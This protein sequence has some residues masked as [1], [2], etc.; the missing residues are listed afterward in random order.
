MTGPNTP[1]ELRNRL[2]DHIVK[3]NVAGLYDPRVEQAMRTVPRHDFIPGASLADAY[4]NRAV[5]IKDNPDADALP[6]SCASQPDVVFFM[7]AQL[8]IQPGDNI[9]EAGAGT[10]YNAALMRH[11]AGPSGQV[12]TLDIHDDVAAHARQRLDDTGFTDVRVLTR[13]AAIGAPEYGPYDRIIATVGIWD[14]PGHL[15]GPAL[16]RWPARP[17][18]ALARPDAQ[19]RLRQGSPLPP[20]GVRRHLRL[21]PDDR[22]GRRA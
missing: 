11:L 20:L 9:L 14:L 13:D 3:T 6:L 12:T 17:P 4:A 10:G 19:C 16:H 2:V 5:T 7:L 18:A 21:P 8:N 15:V 22:P 1:Q